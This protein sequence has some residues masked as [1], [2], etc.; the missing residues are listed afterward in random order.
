M[1]YKSIEGDRP[2]LAAAIH[3]GHE[4]RDEV[5]GNMALDEK[6]RL[7][8][9]DPYTGTLTTIA[10]NQLIVYRSRFEVDLN[11]PREE[12]VYLTPEDAWDLDVRKEP[13]TEGLIKRS[14]RE[15]DSFY[16]HVHQV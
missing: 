11:R 3:N 16:R 12:A 14:L 10:Q 2:L 4:L 7:R 1:F 15:Y 5:A 8:E 6:S 9:E 13:P